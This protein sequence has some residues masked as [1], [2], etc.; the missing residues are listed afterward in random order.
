MASLN[1]IHFVNGQAPYISDVN[2]NG[3]QDNMEVAVSE[4]VA[5]V[6]IQ[7]GTT[8]TNNYEI[9]LPLNYKVGD[10]SLELF[11]NGCALIKQTG[12]NDGHYKEVGESG[13]VSNKIQMYR[14]S[15]DGSYTLT[16]DA[17]LKAI[18]RGV[19]QNA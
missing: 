2:L 3:I 12:T 11:W 4:Q 18:V 13:A 19:D 1:K 15:T 6:K 17:I 7:S 5:F 9:T 10:N 8:I 14:T 16:E